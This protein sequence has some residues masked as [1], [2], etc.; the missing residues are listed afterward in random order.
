M[1]PRGDQLLR[2]QSGFLAQLARRAGDR[3]LSRLQ[4][5]GRDLPE[6]PAGGVA[7]LVHQRHA[8]VVVDGDD[9][10]RPRMPDHLQRDRHAVRQ[11]DLLQAEIDDAALV[12]RLRLAHGAVSLRDYRG[13]RGCG[14]TRRSASNR[15]A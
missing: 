5:A 4:R 8:A 7:E 6:E 9:R 1:L 15:M 11:R 14:I 10:R 13:L 12:D 3:R 2:D